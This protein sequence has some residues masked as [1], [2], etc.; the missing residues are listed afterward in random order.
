MVD[1]AG[2]P[3]AFYCTLN[4][5]AFHYSSQLQT[6][7][8]TRFAARFSTVRAGLRHA[9]D[10]FCQKPGREPQQVRWFIGVLDEWNIEK[11]TVLSKFAA[12][13][14]HAFDLLATRFSTKFAAG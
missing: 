14:R 12:G 9:F 1:L 13:F 4:K 2:Y 3:S 10:Y 11:K 5:A 8:S 7:F 6:W